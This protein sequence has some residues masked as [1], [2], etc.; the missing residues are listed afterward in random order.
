MANLLIY[1]TLNCRFYTTNFKLKLSC[2]TLKMET[3]SSS[4]T[5]IMIRLHGITFYKTVILIIIYIYL[6]TFTLISTPP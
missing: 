3:G 6:I 5:F 2:C 1:T 4:I